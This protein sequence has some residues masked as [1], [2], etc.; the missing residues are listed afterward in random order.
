MLE[1]EGTKVALETDRV[2]WNTG[3]LVWALFFEQHK[4]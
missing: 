4:L 3:S 2:A 1:E